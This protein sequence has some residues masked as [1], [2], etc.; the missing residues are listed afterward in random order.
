MAPNDVTEENSALV[1]RTL[2]PQRMPLFP[3]D[4]KFNVGDRVRYSNL[5][6]PLGKAYKQSWSSEIYVVTAQIA[7]IPV[8]YK[9]ALEE[10]GEPVAGTY[11]S[12]ELS[13]VL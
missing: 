12:E 4:Y 7:R 1:R 9:L 3:P 6:Q 5:K 11:Y 13:K 2:Y 8:V 10:T